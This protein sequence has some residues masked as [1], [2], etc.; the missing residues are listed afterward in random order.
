MRSKIKY[1]VITILI[2]LLLMLGG[3]YMV[4][5]Y[6]YLNSQGTRIVLSIA[7]SLFFLWL[8]G[9]RVAISIYL[10]PKEPKLT[11]RKRKSKLKL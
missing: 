9:T 7:S 4:L 1:H 11:K 8:I 2:E 6:T 10:T 3:L 5:S